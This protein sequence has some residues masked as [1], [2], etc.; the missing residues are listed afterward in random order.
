VHCL[1]LHYLAI[2]LITQCALVLLWTSAMTRYFYGGDVM[3]HFCVIRVT[4][5]HLCCSLGSMPVG[6]LFVPS[7]ASLYR[8]P[9]SLLHQSTKSS[10]HLFFGLS[11][12]F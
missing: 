8:V 9:I 5:L 7:V 11:L 3:S 2:T 6:V 12:Q 1:V 4:F 10:I